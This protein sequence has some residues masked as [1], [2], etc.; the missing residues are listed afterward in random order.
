MFHYIRDNDDIAY[1]IAY[2]I[3]EILEMDFSLL[4][5]FQDTILLRFRC[6][7]LTMELV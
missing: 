1:N 2:L 4:K 3:T 5:R 6:I 7:H